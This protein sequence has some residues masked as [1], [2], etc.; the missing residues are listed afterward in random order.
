M[1]K[2]AILGTGYV[3]LVTGTCFAN[4]GNCVTC[5]DIDKEKIKILS[6]GKIPIYERSLEE[7]VQKNLKI[8]VWHSQQMLRV[9]YTLQKSCLSV[10]QRRPQQMVIVTFL[11]F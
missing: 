3:G 1:K 2:I 8:S 9:H 5:I 6:T 7:L 10:S 4:N 11:I